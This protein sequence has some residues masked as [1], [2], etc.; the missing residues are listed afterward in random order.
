MTPNVDLRRT[1][2]LY[3]VQGR[4]R[5]IEAASFISQIRAHEWAAAPL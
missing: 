5:S 4:S 3:T 1:V 2:T